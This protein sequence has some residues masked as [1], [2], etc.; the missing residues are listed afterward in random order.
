MDSTSDNK[1]VSMLSSSDAKPNGSDIGMSYIDDQ[2]DQMAIS[3]PAPSSPVP[4]AAST[5]IAAHG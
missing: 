5:A 2:P 4:M 1:D 3:T